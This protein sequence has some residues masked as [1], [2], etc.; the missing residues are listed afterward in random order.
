MGR[1]ERGWKWVKRN[2][3]V[4]GMAVAVVLALAVGTTVSYLK[5]RDAERQKQE[6]QKEAAKAE[7]ASDYLVSIFKLADAKG[8]RGTR[9]ARQILDDA[10]KDIPQKF[11]DQPELRDKLLTQI[12]TV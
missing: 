3:L 6:A 1:L 7:R 2:P 12:G 9:T 8:Q 4:T 11:A 5:Y 10:E